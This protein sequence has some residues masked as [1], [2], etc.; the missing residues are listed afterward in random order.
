MKLQ[1]V[2]SNSKKPSCKVCSPP[3]PPRMCCCEK[4]CKIAKKWL[5]WYKTFDNDNSDEFGAESN[6]NSPELPSQPFLLDPTCFFKP[7][8]LR[9]SHFL[10]LGCFYKIQ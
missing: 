6:T 10:Q 4:R 8:F 3:P 5:E 2:K 9:T 7:A 1:K